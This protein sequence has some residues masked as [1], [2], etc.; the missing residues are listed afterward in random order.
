MKDVISY[1]THAQLLPKNS[2]RL[3]GTAAVMTTQVVGIV[4]IQMNSQINVNI[5]I[6]IAT[7]IAHSQMQMLRQCLK[8]QE[9]HLVLLQD[10]SKLILLRLQNT[11]L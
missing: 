3:K 10:V 1:H 4:L 11:H 2:A 9:D 8:I 7:R 5:G 6:A